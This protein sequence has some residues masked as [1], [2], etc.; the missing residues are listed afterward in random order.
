M[1]AWVCGCMGFWVFVCKF[2]A[3]MAWL[4]L[5][6]NL[7]SLKSTEGLRLKQTVSTLSGP[8]YGQDVWVADSP[9]NALV[10]V[11]L[12]FASHVIELNYRKF[13]FQINLFQS[14]KFVR[15]FQCT[16]WHAMFV[17]QLY[18]LYRV[19]GPFRIEL[20]MYFEFQFKSWMH[21]SAHEWT[22]F[23]LPVLGYRLSWGSEVSW[24]QRIRVWK[25]RDCRSAACCELSGSVCVC[26]GETGRNR[27]CFSL[28]SSS[29][30]SA[31]LVQYLRAVLPVP[32]AREAE[33]KPWRMT[34]G[35]CACKLQMCCTAILKCSHYNQLLLLWF[36]DYVEK[37]A[38]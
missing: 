1:G 21:V 37:F 38:L 12:S 20:R 13:L 16:E 34:T 3:F 5:H 14:M 7:R 25:P 11:A 10:M 26:V 31:M 33:I 18:I 19:C 15:S 6:P 27:V 23:V 24:E 29:A 8:S 30:V 2:G 22:S 32:A 17:R 28:L 36:L 4:S 9:F 35:W